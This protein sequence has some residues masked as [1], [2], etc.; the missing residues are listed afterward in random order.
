MKILFLT[1]I[2]PYPPHNGGAIKTFNILKHLGSRHDVELLLYVRNDEEV[3]ALK[4]LAPYCSGI[5]YVPIARSGAD[6]LASAAKSLVAG[7]SFIVTRDWRAAM[8]GKVTSFLESKPD[9]IYVDHLQMFQFVPNPAPCPVLLDEHN[10][11][12]R[13]IERYAAS[14]DT[15]ARRLFASIEWRK[16]RAYELS[17]CGHANLVL[18]VTAH[19]REMLITNGVS[20]DKVHPLPICVDTE[21]VRPVFLNPDSHTILTFGTMSWPP[22]ADSV[23]HFVRSIYPHIKARVPDARFT[24]VGSNPPPEVRAL[25]EG[26]SSITVTGYVDDLIPYA[27]EAAAFVV[28]LRIGSGM[29]V[30]ILDAM[31]LGL[32]VVTTPVGCEGICLQDGHDALVAAEPKHFADAVARLLLD[33]SERTALGKSGRALVE[34]AYSWS[35]VLAELD[36][37]LAAS[38]QPGQGLAA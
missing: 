4:A 23:I 25:A 14:G 32:P 31:A 5:D 28:P 11:E 27:R 35:S 8:Q 36:R 21:G 24:V 30:K 7:R 3:R 33:P 12:W 34:S 6:N 16:L 13:I 18:T 22:N 29:R 38:S 2:C 9:L 10:V 1:Q 26:D 20:G 37:I 15:W 17:A 19:D